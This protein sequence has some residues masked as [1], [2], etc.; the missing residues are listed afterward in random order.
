MAEYHVGCGLAGIY[1]GTILKPGVWKNKNEVT[2]EALRAVAEYMRGQI[3]KGCDTYQITWKFP[4]GRKIIMSL[5]VDDRN[6]EAGK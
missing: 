2:K 5:T 1:A 3:E 4:T 6:V